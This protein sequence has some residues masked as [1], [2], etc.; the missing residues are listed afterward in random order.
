VVVARYCG[1]CGKRRMPTLEA[2][3]LGVQGK[4]RFGVSIQSLVALLHGRHRVPMREIGAFLEE[5]W[6]LHVSAGEVVA[7]LDGVAEAGKVEYT[8]LREQVQQAGVVCA[9]ETGWR[10]NG[11]NG[12]LWT[13]AT[14]AGRYFEFHPTR[15]GKVAEEVLGEDFRGVISCDCYVGYNRLLAEKQRCWAHLLRDVH[16]L[17][18]EH[19]E[20]PEVR[21]WA[22]QVQG[23][24]AEAKAFVSPNPVRRRT[25]RRA[26]ERR[27]D[28]LVRR[29][30][31]KQGAP[32]RVLAQRIRQHLLE[33]FVFV[34]RPEV[35]SDN[36][37]AERSLRPAVIARKISG[38]TRT[39]KGSA[40]KTGLLSL[41][42]TWKLRE[43]SPLRTCQH[44]LLTD[45]P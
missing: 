38:G 6:G 1:M 29:L 42:G 11:R 26:L 30:S 21:A 10:E 22:Q 15:A 27:L 8:R 3:A 45:C 7:L 23:L 39:A 16:A 24:Y 9:D 34:E 25:M 40:T 18:E 20:E 4:R 41:F 35:P 2:A 31:Q 43:L 19:A 12:F 14:S 17:K 32:Q 33:W 37:L 5:G 44:L 36:N 28:A 13:F